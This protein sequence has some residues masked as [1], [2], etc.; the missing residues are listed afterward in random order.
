MPVSSQPQYLLPDLLVTWPWGR[1]FNPML[2]EI[3]DQ[4]NSWV[5]SLDLFEPAQL[6]KFKACDFS[7]LI[8][9]RSHFS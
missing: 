6:Q 7:N 3:K 8:F 4:A 1:V 9:T 5:E 2:D